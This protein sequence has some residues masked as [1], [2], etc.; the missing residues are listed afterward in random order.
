M[1][2]RIRASAA[3]VFRQGHGAG[4]LVTIDTPK[5]LATWPQV[6]GEHGCVPLRD[7]HAAY[8]DLAA[9]LDDEGAAGVTG[10][11]IPARLRRG[12]VVGAPRRITDSAGKRL[13]HL[14]ALFNRRRAT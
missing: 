14:A 12:K 6:W 1:V 5:W 2:T 13:D 8:E 11:D 3:A 4:Q 7:K 9:T 10:T